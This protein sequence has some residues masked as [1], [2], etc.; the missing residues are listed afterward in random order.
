MMSI[1]T[2]QWYGEEF[3]LVNDCELSN[4]DG[5]LR[6][7]ELETICVEFTFPTPEILASA[8]QLIYGIGA[9]TAARLQNEGYRT[10]QDLTA[11]LLVL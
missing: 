3:K 2:Q 7:L 10:F 1:V 8:F 11:H 6:L 9:I 5:S 4:A